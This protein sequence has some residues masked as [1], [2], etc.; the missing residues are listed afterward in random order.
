M[1]LDKNQRKTKIRLGDLI[2]FDYRRQTVSVTRPS[3]G[4]EMLTFDQRFKKP[5]PLLNID[6]QCDIFFLADLIADLCGF[7]A[8]LVR[9]TDH[10]QTF[11]IT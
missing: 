2:T 3:T 9:K 11:Q 10:C 1:L 7:E 6:S 5:L 4:Y 8:D